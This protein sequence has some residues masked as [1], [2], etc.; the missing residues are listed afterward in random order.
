MKVLVRTVLALP[1]SSS[2]SREGAN[3]TPALRVLWTAQVEYVLDNMEQQ[4]TVQPL[5]DEEMPLTG[6]A[7]AP[8]AADGVWPVRIPGASQ[9]PAR[10]WTKVWAG[11]AMALVITDLPLVSDL[12]PDQEPTTRAGCL[13]CPVL[14]PD[15]WYPFYRRTG[16]ANAATSSTKTLQL[17]HQCQAPDRS[18]L[19]IWCQRLLQQ[20]RLR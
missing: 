7:S 15:P 14:T 12:T 11:R 16:N 18:R 13:T 10:V 17:S 1:G 8:V 2:S 6:V 9:E 20:Q 19:R 3:S 4:A 5:S